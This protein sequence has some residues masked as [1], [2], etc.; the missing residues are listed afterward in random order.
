MS[1]KDEKISEGE[2]RYRPNRSCVDLVYTFG[3]TIKGRK[4]AGQTV[5]CFFLDVQKAYDTVL[6]NGMWKIW[7]SEVEKI[8]KELEGDQ[9]EVLSKEKFGG[10]KTRAK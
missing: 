4:D 6:R 2:A 10:Y 7:D 1:E 3:K 8:W 9:E 5:Y